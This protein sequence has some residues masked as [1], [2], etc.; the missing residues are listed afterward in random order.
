MPYTTFRS[1]NL[2]LTHWR[3]E[4][5]SRNLFQGVM[6]WCNWSILDL[7]GYQ[8]VSRTQASGL[9]GGHPARL[10]P[11]QDPN[12]TNGQV[13]EANRADWVWEANVGYSG[14]AP[15]VASG[16]YVSG[17]FY[18]TVSTTGTYAH[19]VNFP[20][21]RVVFNTAINTNSIIEADYSYRAVSFVSSKEPWFTQLL[22]NS[23]KIER[24]DFL[25]PTGAWSHL[26]QARRQMPAVG[27]ELVNRLTSYPY[28]IGSLAQYK[29][30]DMLLY[31]LAENDFDR[32][33]IVDILTSQV[34]HTVWLPDR[35]RI[36]SYS[37]YPID[38]DYRGSP[39]S[40][41]MYYPDVISNFSWIPVRVTNAVAQSIETIN[42]WLYRGVVRMT[43]QG[44]I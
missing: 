8:N 37:G 22:Y 7:G 43:F 27:L 1:P 21:G 31:V 3:N 15:T 29:N 16:V 39:V 38:L 14:T 19:H 6:D 30:Q 41:P 33:Q 4:Q 32:D 26:A 17:V 18:P 5:F 20:L 44:I 23:H 28:E 11:V 42:S 2:N 36:K 10:R 25:S 35:A 34:D 9:Y 12:Y 13:W 40:S 24:S